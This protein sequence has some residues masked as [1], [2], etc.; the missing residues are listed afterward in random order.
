MEEINL[1]R[2]PDEI[3]DFVLD[4]FVDRMVGLEAEEALESAL[5][6]EYIRVD[7][8]SREIVIERSLAE[9]VVMDALSEKIMDIEQE[10]ATGERDDYAQYDISCWL[11]TVNMMFEEDTEDFVQTETTTER[12]GQSSAVSERK[13]GDEET[14]EINRDTLSFLVERAEMEHRSVVKD[15]GAEPEF[16]E[17]FD[18][19]LDEAK[20]VLANN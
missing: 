14:V 8:A 6:N 1:A 12:S 5:A 18:N 3:A 11:T 20:A 10:V 2:F 15:F 17:Q 9:K 13:E 16:L 7:H 19:A 4:Q